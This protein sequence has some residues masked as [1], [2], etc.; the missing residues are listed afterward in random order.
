VFRLQRRGGIDG[1]VLGG[2]AFCLRFF[3][4]DGDDRLMLVNL[5]RDLDLAV[6]PEPLLAPPLGLEWGLLWSSESPDYGGSGTP[7]AAI[8]ERWRLPGHSALVLNARD[9]SG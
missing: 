2:E 9:S 6:L 4:D 7:D 5:G 8:L 3:G 1:A